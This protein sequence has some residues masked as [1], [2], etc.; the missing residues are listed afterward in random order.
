M[1]QVTDFGIGRFG[2]FGFMM[3]LED[4]SWNNMFEKELPKYKVSLDT[5]FPHRPLETINVNTT[6]NHVFSH[7]QKIALLAL[8]YVVDY[9]S[10]PTLGLPNG[11]DKV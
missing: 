8:M 4:A 11:K 3:D 9:K 1:V 5:I 2:A 6:F 7:L 10:L